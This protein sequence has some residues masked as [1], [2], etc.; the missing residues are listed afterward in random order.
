MSHT[1]TCRILL[2]DD[3]TLLMEGVRSLLRPHTDIRVVGMAANG[4]EALS[5][6]A[7]H[8]PHVVIM[9]ISM[10]GMNGV[11]ATRA[12]REVCPTTKVIIY[13]MHNDQR[14]LLELFHAGIAG[15]VLKG[16]PP[17]TLLQAIAT[18]REGKVFFSSADPGGQLTGM[19]REMAGIPAEDG[20]RALSPREK[21]IFQ[22]LADDKS[23]RDIAEGLH[24]SPKTVET[25]KYNVL[26]KLHVSSMSEL[27]KLAIRYGLVKV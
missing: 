14:F 12:V 13:T 20:L 19:M 27:T 18:V 9:D 5:L 25:H 17:A 26:T 2:V 15:H 3:H 6:A 23:I 1:D 7:A 8:M 11:E 16:D 24:I 22:M 10:P 21:Q 4:E